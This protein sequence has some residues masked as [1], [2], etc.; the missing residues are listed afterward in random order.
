M[1]SKKN[2]SFRG[3]KL[4]RRDF[5]KTTAYVGA[6]A[7]VP[8]MIHT[9]GKLSFAAK[10]TPKVL[11]TPD[12]RI[13]PYQLQSG[14]A[15]NVASTIYD[16]LFRLE[17]AEQKFTCSLAEFTEN[18]PDM[19]QWTIKLREKVKFHHGTEFTADDLIFTVKVHRD[20]STGSPLLT[21]FR[22]IEKV[23]KIDRYTVRFHLNRPDPDFLLIFLDKKAAMLAH[24]YDYKQFGNTK[25]S[26]TGA[27][28]VVSYTPGQRMLLERNPNYFVQGLPKS[29]NLEIVFMADV[30]TQLMVLEAGQADIIRVLPFPQVPR[31]QQLGQVTLHR[32]PVSYHCPVAMRCDQ[33][34]FNDN[35]VRT[36]MKLVVDRKKML[37]TVA[38]GYGELANDDYVWSKN[39]WHNDIG[40]KE[41]DIDK[42]KELLAQAG[43]SKGLD[44]EIFCQSNRPPGM[45][46]VL[47]FQEM[48]K[49]AGINVQIRGVTTDIY[50]AKHFCKSTAEVTVWG[51]RE[52]P[53]NLLNVNTRTGARINEGH[54]S[55]PEVD[56]LLDEAGSETDRVK[57]KES[58]KKLQILLSEDGPIVLPFF[59]NVFAATHKRLKGFQ[60]TRN[61]INDFRAVEIV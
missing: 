55:N 58:F 36:A 14:G 22:H 13:T 21:L 41:R 53:L 25:P 46:M 24:D 47:T 12:P 18:S 54:Y 19:T 39:E 51:H 20:K 17:G 10:K 57:R 49:P 11:M 31:Y 44:V 33:P 56:R 50:Y 59:F 28:K 37:D 32:L 3:K 4:T 16:W 29:D 1:E 38:L 15:I 9:S 26:G 43:Y 5:L 61:F 52:N 8:G 30:Q 35:R 45:D 34:P 60:L 48:A 7:T 2:K 40:I 42:A 6:A 27:F 23:E